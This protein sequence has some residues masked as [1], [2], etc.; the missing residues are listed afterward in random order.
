[1]KGTAISLNLG[2]LVAPD[3][4]PAGKDAKANARREKGLQFDVI[5]A[6][7]RTPENL[8][9]V[10]RRHRQ[11][12]GP[13]ER[14]LHFGL[15]SCKVPPAGPGYGVKPLKG[16]AVED[17]FRAGEVYGVEEY[18]L[19]SKESIYYSNIREPLGRSFH[20]G[21]KLPDRILKPEFRGFGNPSDLQSLDTKELICPRDLPPETKEV[22]DMYAKTHGNYGPGQSVNRRYDWPE[23]IRDSPHFAFGLSDNVERGGA[24]TGA[25][26]A[27]TMD[28][29]LKSCIISQDAVNFKQASTDVL[30]KSKC[31]THCVPPVPIGHYYGV[32]SKEDEC[33]AAMLLRGQYSVS[34]QMP[35][36]DLG[37][38][39][40]PGRRN[41]LTE[42]PL[43]IPS[44]RHDIKALPVW[45]RS[46]TNATNWG[47][48]PSA[49][50]VIFPGSLHSRGITDMDFKV[51]RSPS[52]LRSIIEGAG[53]TWSNQ[54][55]EEVL[56]IAAQGAGDKLASVEALM[57]ALVLPARQ[58]GSLT[59]RETSKFTSLS[60]GDLTRR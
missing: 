46:V 6:T 56:S 45:K 51:L 37:R 30:S 19:T 7:P 22:K 57:E 4:R 18:V 2:N 47:D 39:I 44:I 58:T 29:G 9:E 28:D 16:D 20:R 40:I 50:G 10:Q 13:S 3:V 52:E 14:V 5:V 21:H 12:G 33:D 25:K 42:A 41:F 36:K 49:R 35:D 48:E 34:E 24:G 38:C 26:S 31:S 53:Y 17:I 23:E 1:M 59:H 11:K 8:N 60:R 43:G 54:E 15:K 32:S 27:L 55:F